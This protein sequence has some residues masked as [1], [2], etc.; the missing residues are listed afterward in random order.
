[1][2]WNASGSVSGPTGGGGGFSL[3][4]TGGSAGASLSNNSQSSSVDFLLPAGQDLTQVQVSMNLNGG[5][6]PNTTFSGN[7]SVSN[8]R[9]EVAIAPPVISNVAAGGITGSGATITW[10]TDFNSDSQVEYGPTTAYGQSTTL[11]PALV[12]SHS[13]GLSGL[14][15]D[16]LYHYRVKSKNAP[17]NL[18]MSGDFTFRT[19]DV[20]PPVIYIIAV[21]EHQHY[22]YGATQ[23]LQVNAGDRVYAYVYLDPANI[24]Q[25]VMLQ[26]NSNESGWGH[27]A[28][29]GANNIPW[30]TDGT[31]DRKHM[32]P[33]PAAG[34]W[35]RLEVDASAVG[36]EGKTLNG[37]AF[38]L[39]GGRANWDNAG[40]TNGAGDIAWVDDALPAGASMG[41]DGGDGWTWVGSSPNPYSGTVSTQ[42]NIAAAGITKSDA[43]ITWA[44]NEISDSQVE[45]GTDQTYGYSTTLNP[46]L[47]TAHSQV[48][49]GLIA[50]TTYHYR[51][52]SRDAAGNLAV[53]SDFTFTTLFGNDAAFVSQSVPATMIAGE[54]Y[55]VTVSML[56]EG[57]NTW[58][59]GQLYRLGSQNPQDNG[60]WGLGRVN[61]LAGDSVSQGATTTFSFV[62]TAPS[63]PGS[64]NFQWQ[65]VQDGVEWFG[66]KTPNIAVQVI[67][68]IDSAKCV[69]NMPL[70]LI[71][72]VPRAG[73]G[74]SIASTAPSQ[75]P[76][77][78]GQKNS[79]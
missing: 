13:Q 16:T 6:G 19:P 45:Y 48:L 53:S 66:A 4:Y 70:P 63:S 39:Y 78:C 76:K 79:D 69:P 14:N 60:T 50:G 21:G 58:T 41:S 73:G 31:A 61:L 37:I 77:R 42:S 43:I 24:P 29:W 2:D 38:T 32:G 49:S 65:M 8:I 11:N 40:K 36:L 28:Y 59:P 51:V 33:L 44:T 25:E 17:G 3:A 46:A 34:R 52:K 62:V 30:G 67:W 68:R 47:V 72:N 10:N 35:V 64:Y 71:G 55:A 27:R 18:V 23:T 20:T 57:T 15:S 54:T 5:A 9:I 12:T 1:M 7:A 26:W 75:A 22:F 74:E 56:N